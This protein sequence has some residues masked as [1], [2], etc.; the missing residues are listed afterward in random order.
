MKHSH[1][2]NHILVN[3]EQLVAE[4]SN[5]MKKFCEFIN[6]EFD[7]TMLQDYGKAAQYLSLEKGGRTVSQEIKNL[8]LINLIKYLMNLKN[9][10]F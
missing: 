3:Y 10:I 1:K 4:T 2:S 6:V 5:V 8:I 7:E 9:S